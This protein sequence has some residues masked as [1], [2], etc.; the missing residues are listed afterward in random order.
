MA[1]NVQQPVDAADYGDKEG[2]E[3]DVQAV[4]MAAAVGASSEPDVPTPEPV[5]QQQPQPPQQQMAQPRNL[6]QI[7]PQA[8]LFKDKRQKLPSQVRYD[9]GLLWKVLLSDP[10]VSDMTKAIANRLL[11]ED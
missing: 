9:A 7:V 8:L 5:P 10:N 2:Q 1:E 6:M 4:E 3:Q 11:G